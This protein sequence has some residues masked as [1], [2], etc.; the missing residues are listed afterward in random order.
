MPTSTKSVPRVMQRVAC[1]KQ[2]DQAHVLCKQVRKVC[3]Q[4][5][6]E[7]VCEEQPGQGHLVT[8]ATYNKP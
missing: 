5:C 8:A 3:N 7:E 1:E 2:R 6:R 4:Q